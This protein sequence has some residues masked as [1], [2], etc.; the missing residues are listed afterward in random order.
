MANRFE[1]FLTQYKWFDSTFPKNQLSEIP[2]SYI[3]KRND[4]SG[5]GLFSDNGSDCTN[6]NPFSA[7]YSYSK[8]KI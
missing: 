3:G 5:L 1:E 8:E 6:I 4:P 7:I 2:I